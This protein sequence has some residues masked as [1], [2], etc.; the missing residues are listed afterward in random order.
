MNLMRN[1]FGVV[2][3]FVLMSTVT[4]VRAQ[5]AVVDVA[6][7]AKLVEQL[8]TARSHLEQAQLQYESMTG[9]RGMEALLAWLACVFKGV[10]DLLDEG[11][12]GQHEP[13]Y[14][15]AQKQ[16]R[17]SSWFVAGDEREPEGIKNGADVL[18]LQLDRCLTASVQHL[19]QLQV[20]IRLPVP[21]L[22]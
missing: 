12:V 2:S 13:L 8:E 9:P 6:A 15:F 16:L 5:M 18:M 21:L 7:I 19:T 1:T 10:N 17:I 22:K 3:M 11:W 4:P 20:V 14:L